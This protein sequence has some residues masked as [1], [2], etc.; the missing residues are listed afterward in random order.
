ME[1]YQDDVSISERLET[2]RR[3][4][5]LRKAKGYPDWI[6][7]RLCDISDETLRRYE[8]GERWMG[9]DTAM[10]LA[11]ILGV[12]TDDFLPDG[13]FERH[14]PPQRLL[15]QLGELLKFPVGTL[16]EENRGNRSSRRS[17]SASSLT[18]AAP[19]TPRGRVAGK[20]GRKTSTRKSREG[21]FPTP[22]PLPAAILTKAA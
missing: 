13:F 4:R 15:E 6:V 21:G 3:I 14:T 16:A 20:Q 5:E 2:G 22:A 11:A 1:L 7:A 18:N 8:A 17:S 19:K 10:R 12:R 9:F